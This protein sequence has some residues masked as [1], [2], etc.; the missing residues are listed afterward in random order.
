MTQVCFD[1]SVFA[2][3]VSRIPV[4]HARPER[5]A[6]SNPHAALTAASTGQ[7][8]Q[9]RTSAT[10]D[11]LA[12]QYNDLGCLYTLK[13]LRPPQASEE[14]RPPDGT[15]RFVT[16]DTVAL[17][18]WPRVLIFLSRYTFVVALTTARCPTARG[19]FPIPHLKA[20]LET[21]SVP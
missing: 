2:W 19:P 7:Q 13:R 1:S 20:Y 8:K 15:M 14:V 18:L 6:V 17:G 16:N 10:L 11:E 12:F 9:G 3:A 5:S 4:V 21:M